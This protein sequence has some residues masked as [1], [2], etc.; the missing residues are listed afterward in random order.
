V[1]GNPAYM[2]GQSG[3]LPSGWTFPTAA[4]G[5]AKPE[6]SLTER[7]SWVE[8]RYFPIG[9]RTGSLQLRL[10]PQRPWRKREGKKP[11]S[12]QTLSQSNNE[13]TPSDEGKPW[14]ENHTRHAFGQRL[15]WGKSRIKWLSIWL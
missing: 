1:E 8:H 2:S 3:P 10:H 13:K 14:G 6:S 9:W 11:V 4:N 7:H 15:H 5:C 12:E